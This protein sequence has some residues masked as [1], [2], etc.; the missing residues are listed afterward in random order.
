MYAEV[1]SLVT[2]NSHIQ[3]ALKDS[4]LPDHDLTGVELEMLHRAA[5]GDTSKQ[6]AGAMR[7]S[8]QTVKNR[9][10]MICAKVRARNRTHACVMAVQ[11]GWIG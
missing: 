1:L 11:R 4:G 6:I 10:R 8:E 9:F 2:V 7:T 3:V 5:H